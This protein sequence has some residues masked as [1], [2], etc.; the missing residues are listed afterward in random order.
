MRFFSLFLFLAFGLSPIV[1]ANGVLRW[2]FGARDMGAAGAFGGTEG[3]AIAA[4]QV[5][6]ALLSTLAENQWTLSSRYLRGD[7]DFERGGMTSGLTD[8][9][10]VYPDF[11]FSWCPTD[12]SITFG[13]GV[14]PVSALEA[15]WNYLD[16]P[17]GIGGISYGTLEHESRF[18]ALRFAL[19]SSWQLHDQFAIGISAGAIYSE[20]DFNAPF[21]FQTNHALANAKVDLDMETD[22]WAPSVEIGTLYRPTSQ[23]TF[24]SRLKVPVS[25]DNQGSANVDFSAQLPALGLD[26]DS[27]LAKYDARA[28]TRL[29][30]TIGAGTAWQP[31]DHWTIGLWIDWHQ[32]SNAYDAFGVNL[33]NGSNADINGAIGSS[34]SDR[35]PLDWKDRFVF[36]LGSACELSDEWTLRG[37]YRHGESPVPENRVTPL[38]GATHWRQVKRNPLNF[39][40][41][42][43]KKSRKSLDM[44]SGPAGL[45]CS[46]AYLPAAR[47]S[48]CP[49]SISSRRKP[50]WSRVAPRSSAPPDSSKPSSA[51][52]SPDWLPSTNSPTRSRTSPPA[53]WPASPSTNASTGAPWPSS[54][55]CSTS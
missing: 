40:R 46:K 9:E 10:G 33:S 19:A 30:L 4:V 41:L 18:V 38:N 39:S 32:W 29:P 8:D 51:R 26:P 2:G 55:R 52:S 7:S 53:P 44:K 54:S 42:G 12:S 34:P 48:L 43:R 27:P 25:L 13:F 35:I 24:G 3:D 45:V 49:I 37:G 20:I 47:R 36:S 28:R 21:I 1:L 50:V 16:A 22:G 11:A 5:N 31:T 17:G 23:W 14:S 6:P 15:K